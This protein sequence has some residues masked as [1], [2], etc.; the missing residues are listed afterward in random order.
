[1]GEDIGL[2]AY[3]R[4][5]GRYFSWGYLPHEDKYNR[6]TIERR[7]AAVVM[8]GGIYDGHADTHSPMEQSFTRED[9]AH[10][11][12]DEPDG[13]HPFERTTTPPC[14]TPSAA[15][16]KPARSRAS[17]SRAA[18]MAKAGS[19][20]IRWSSTCTTRAAGRACFSGISRGCTRW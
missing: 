13:L 6:P 17:S 18:G 2:G 3:G 15:G 5:H 20:T 1:M 4:G 9:M 19:T 12:Y 7:H 8:K 14:G 11:W 10:A 16:S